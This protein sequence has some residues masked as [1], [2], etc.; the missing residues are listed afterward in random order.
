MVE[1]FTDAVER[2]FAEKREFAADAVREVHC[3]HCAAPAGAR[4]L[5]RAGWYVKPHGARLARLHR[6]RNARPCFRCGALA[7]KC[8]CAE[9]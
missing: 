6:L 4:C 7:G 9:N 5:S 2:H 3:D 1:T 8:D